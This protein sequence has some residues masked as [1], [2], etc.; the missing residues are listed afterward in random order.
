MVE[1]RSDEAID[2]IVSFIL[3]AALCLIGRVERV[4]TVGKAVHAERGGESHEL[5]QLVRLE[6]SLR[7]W[8]GWWVNG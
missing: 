4:R 8:D 2:A 7:A 5:V 6:R 3:G 1:E